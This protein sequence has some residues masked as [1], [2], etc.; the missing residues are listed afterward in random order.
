MG[1]GPAR[2]DP[3]VKAS[4]HRKRLRT[5]ALY[6]KGDTVGIIRHRRNSP[7]LQ[8]GWSDFLGGSF[9]SKSLETAVSFLRLGGECG[10]AALVGLAREIAAFFLRGE[11]SCGLAFD[12][13]SIHRRRFGGFFMPWHALL[14]AFL[15]LNA[16]APDPGLLEAAREAASYCL[17]W[18]FTFDV[19]CDPASRLGALAFHTFGGTA[20][21][22]VHHHLDPYGLTIALDFLRL[23]TGLTDKRWFDYARDLMGFC[24]QAVS[25]PERP[26][27]LGTDFIGYQQEQYNQ[28][29]WDYI[30]HLVGGKGGYGFP[31]SWVASSTLGACLDIREEFPEYVPGARRLSLE[32]LAKTGD[33]RYP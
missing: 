27:N 31:A 21:S 17:S 26:L 19:P 20:V 3:S 2:R 15:L 29:N 5:H 30:H 24:G 12:D 7:L 28:T 23:G 13:Y 4:P 8:R 1:S 16:V 25:T 32:M 22:V 9:L 6:R 11:L 10:D 33:A 14:R 18:Q